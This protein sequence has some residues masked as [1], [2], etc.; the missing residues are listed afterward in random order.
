MSL[1]KYTSPFPD[2]ELFP[3]RMFQDS[4]NRLFA[5]PN[6]RPWVPAVDIQET[7]NELILKA[8]VPEVEMK[9]IDVRLENG[10]LTIRGERKFEAKKNEG[11]WHRVERGYGSFERAFT[12]PDTVSPEGVKAEYKNGVLTVTL[13]KKEV[14]K[15]RQIKVEVTH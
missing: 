11:G 10:T 5:E 8:D 1:I 4:M 12:V 14:A 2:F 3:A 7:E 13:P 15:P 6:G 9:D